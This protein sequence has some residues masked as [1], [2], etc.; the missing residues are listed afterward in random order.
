[1]SVLT[2]ILDRLTDITT[3]RAQISEL[4]SQQREMRALVLTQ[5]KEL[6]ELRGQLKTL[7]Q[8]Q[9]ATGRR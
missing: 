7:I 8:M 4:I 6:A 9:V 3:L 1:M 2:D 5:Q